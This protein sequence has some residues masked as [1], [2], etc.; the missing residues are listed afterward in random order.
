MVEQFAH[1]SALAAVGWAMEGKMACYLAHVHSVRTVIAI[2]NGG[3]IRA[4]SCMGAIWLDNGGQMAC[5]LAQVH[6]VRTV[7][8]PP[9]GGRIML[10]FVYTF[11]APFSC[12]K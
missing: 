3:T 11:V 6:S 8:A 7:I 9:N 12:T 1:F 5:Y 2:A 10:I 4:F